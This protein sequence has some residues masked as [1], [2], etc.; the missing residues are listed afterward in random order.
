VLQDLPADRVSHSADHRDFRGY[1]GKEIAVVGGGQSALE[2]AALLRENG[3]LPVV[4]VR[5]QSL[6]WNEYPS[7]SLAPI[8]DERPPTLRERIPRPVATLGAGWR[9]WV[10]AELPM[11]VFALPAA[12]RLRLVREVL[13]PAGAW[14]LRDRVEGHV[15]ILLGHSVVGGKDDNGRVRLRVA[16]LGAAESEITVDNVIA[17]TGY[18]VSLDRL[19]FLDP[20][21]R[22]RLR[23]LQGAP[24]LSSHFES[25]VPGLYF[26]GLAAANSFGP[27][28]RFVCGAGFAGRR[29]TAHVARAQS[30]RRAL[31]SQA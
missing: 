21:L 2:T 13:G 24:I 18:R 28:M 8:K 3:A 6:F 31:R 17:A 10:Y 1:E 29:V 16:A 7:S 4:L 25:S 15:T 27:V 14:W 20:Q 30:P 5:S 9:M 22:K 11:V 12:T 26:V 19:S 23:D